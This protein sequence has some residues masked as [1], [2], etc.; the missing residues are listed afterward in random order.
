[1]K[2]IEIPYRKILDL[3]ARYGD[4]SSTIRVPPQV[5]DKIVEFLK[6]NLKQHTHFFEDLNSTDIDEAIKEVT[7]KALEK[8][9][10]MF[11]MLHS[12]KT[13]D[14]DN[15]FRWNLAE[16]KTFINN[17]LFD[18]ILAETIRKKD[19]TRLL[20]KQKEQTVTYGLPAPGTHP[21]NTVTLEKT[22]KTDDKGTEIDIIEEYIGDPLD[23]LSSM[24]GINVTRKD[25]ESLKNEQTLL[26]ATANAKT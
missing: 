1:M 25:I 8:A 16:L 5:L 11:G 22:S 17:K 20:P 7:R 19:L 23:L 21:N 9:K 18:P 6:A 2:P 14:K 24:D 3:G 15:N 12:N 4:L 13:P 26:G 10:V